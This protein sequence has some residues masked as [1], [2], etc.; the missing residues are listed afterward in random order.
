[1]GIDEWEAALPQGGF[2][3]FHTPQAL[4]VLEAHTDATLRLYGAFK[5]EVPVG[6]FPV[7]VGSRAGGRLVT[8]PPP[9]MSVPRLGPIVMPT[10]PKQRK[11][12]SV[13]RNFVEL[14]LDEVGADS[15]RSLVR[16]VCPMTYDD[17]RP[18]QWADMD[19]SQSFTYVLDLRSETTESIRSQF[20]KSLR[21]EIRR[22]EAA[23]VSVSLEGTEA[24]E[25]IYDD[26][27][28]R[29]AEQDETFPVGREYFRDLVGT[30]RDRCRVYTARDANGAF[31]GGIVV[32]YSDDVAAFWQGG[33]RADY[34][35]ASVNSYLHWR[36][37]ADI[38]RGDAP[39]V[40]GYDLVGAN[41]PNL[42]RYKSK[43]GADLVAYNTVESAGAQ[44]SV[45]KRAYSLISN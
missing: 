16:F 37:I 12:E 32:L 6:L 24:A 17:P 29:Y 23:D 2:E 7:F 10:S 30:L 39:D 11:R 14:V 45:A 4:R 31:L 21:R 9:G 41:T 42:C 19:V 20:S 18:F 44:M 13:N 38:I 3:V 1:M 28:D 35:G 40:W 26:V 34:D 8:S 25:R 33:V 22:A 36:I 5:G 15:A 43:F 27:A